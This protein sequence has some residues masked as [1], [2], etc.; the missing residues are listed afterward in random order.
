MEAILSN[1][2]DFPWYVVRLRSNF[3]KIGARDF[4]ARGFPAFLPLY[5]TFRRWSDRVKEIEAPLFPGYVFCKFDPQRKLSILTCPGVVSILETANGPIPVPDSDIAAVQTMLRS[6]LPVGPWPFLQQGQPVLVERGPL[7]G[8]EGLIVKI[9]DNYRLVV[10]VA[11]LQRSVS[12]EIDREWVRPLAP[13]PPL[14]VIRPS[15][16]PVLRARA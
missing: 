9:K 7:K 12:A 8:L 3:E 2:S 1:N 5:R 15:S 13:A 16:Q 10:S 6:G 14:P 4:E 11:L